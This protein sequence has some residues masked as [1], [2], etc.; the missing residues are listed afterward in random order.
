M[1]IIIPKLWV[2][3]MHYIQ[4]TLYNAFHN[5]YLN[6]ELADRFARNH[7]Y[8]LRALGVI[9]DNCILAGIGYLN[10]R[11]AHVSPSKCINILL[12]NNIITLAITTF[13]CFTWDW[14]KPRALQGFAIFHAVVS[15][16]SLG[17]ALNNLHSH[18][19][20]APMGKILLIGYV[21]PKIIFQ[22]SV[23]IDE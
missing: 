4:S 2:N 6:P 1:G 13:F 3:N 12:L 9:A 18:K 23:M 7:P 11:I 8:V 15:G 19:L 10:G 17:L 22:T 20:L 16:I 5:D 21:V 14:S